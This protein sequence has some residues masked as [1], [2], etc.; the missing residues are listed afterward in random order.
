MN[1]VKVNIVKKSELDSKGK[2]VSESFVLEICDDS[3]T[4][5]IPGTSFDSCVLLASE[6]K[7]LDNIWNNC[8][9]IEAEYI[10]NLLQ[11]LDNVYYMFGEK[12]RI[13]GK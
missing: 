12:R 4:I 2:E 7:L 8:S 11:N 3:T 5:Q 10:I 9:F 13:I 6:D 1:N